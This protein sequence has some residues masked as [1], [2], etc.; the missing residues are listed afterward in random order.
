[1]SV[2]PLGTWARLGLVGMVM[3]GLVMF[4]S[5]RA[6]A[7]ILRHVDAD[8]VIWFTNL[9]PTIGERGSPQSASETQRPTR[10]ARTQAHPYRMEVEQLARRHGLSANLVS[11]LMAV[12]SDFDPTAVSTK[13]AQGLMQLMPLIAE[14]YRVYNP[15]NPQQNIEGGIRYLSDLLQ[16]F[17]NQLPLAIA[18]YNG[19]EG[20]VRKH[21]GVPPV[22]ES[23]VNKVLTLY[24]QAR[25]TQIHRYIMPSGV[26]L[27][28]NVPLSQEQLSQWDVK[29]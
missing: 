18:A 26:M 5:P 27:F 16:L 19:G 2:S 8:G 20:L 3:C 28:S 17:D 23:Y 4:H 14:H 1:L 13:G 29:R 21:G 11:A 12:E 15:F 6:W 24:E 7:K 22:L 25:G 9:P 10:A